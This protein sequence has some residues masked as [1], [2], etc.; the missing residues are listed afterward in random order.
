[1]SHFKIVAGGL[2]EATELATLLQAFG[3]R[4]LLCYYKKSEKLHNRLQFG[5]EKKYFKAARVGRAEFA[6]APVPKLGPS[7]LHALHCHSDHCNAA[8][9]TVTDHSR[10]ARLHRVSNDWLQS[11]VVL[12]CI[13]ITGGGTARFLVTRLIRATAQQTRMIVD[14][15]WLT[16]RLATHIHS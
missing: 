10:S 6:T 3:K 8:R 13:G 4:Y 14:G 12:A 1:V 7:P 11:G 2:P 16:S 15:Q 5:A 9:Y